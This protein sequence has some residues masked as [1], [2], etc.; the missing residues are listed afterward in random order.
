M[1]P[2]RSQPAT[3]CMLAERSQGLACGW[4][5]N[6]VCLSKLLI[7]QGLPRQPLISPAT[8]SRV[9]SALETATGNR[10]HQPSLPSTVECPTSLACRAVPPRW[11]PLSLCNLPRLHDA[12]SLRIPGW[13]LLLVQVLVQQ[14]AFLFSPLPPCL[15]HSCLHFCPAL[16]THPALGP[17][18]RG[19]SSQAV[20]AEAGSPLVL[21]APKP[22]CHLHA[23]CGMLSQPPS[24][25]AGPVHLN[26]CRGAGP[27]V[28]TS[29]D[30]HA[31]LADTS[32]MRG[33]AG[34]IASPTR[35]EGLQVVGSPG[36][37][38]SAGS[39]GGERPAALGG[40]LPMLGRRP[41]SVLAKYGAPGLPP[42]PPG[43][44]EQ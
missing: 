21:V 40:V 4:L 1:E 20:A 13:A 26:V 33:G 10:C 23:L 41:S 29:S 36:S 37:T 24:P 5:H 18:N 17:C 7:P 42:L 31:V 12:P 27:L 2:A 22:A 6:A 25:A 15:H 44:F 3:A 11:P 35:G 8:P 9:P 30:A 28:M 19:H 43:P 16:G 14:E 32:I 39:E 38:G 34:G